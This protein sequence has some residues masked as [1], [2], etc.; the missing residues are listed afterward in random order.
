M[1]DLPSFADTAP[2]L[3]QRE[4]LRAFLDMWLVDHGFIRDIY[5]NL[6]RIS[7][8]AW[9]SAQ[10]APRHL[11]RA[12]RLGV[13]TVLNLRGRRDT[14]G[15]YILEREACQRL[16]LA[17]VDFP[18]RSRSPL[19]RDTLKAAAELFPQLEYPILMHCKSGADRAGLMATLYLHLHEGV[20]MRRAM[21][22]LSLRYG[23]IRHAKTGVSDF[24]FETYLKAS[25]ASPIAFADWVASHYDPQELARQFRQNW[26]AAVLVDRILRRE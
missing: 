6:H 26:A 2:A 7:E 18:I 15:S 13:R 21:G 14:C 10:P 3:T 25:A 5:C 8:N 4:R 22:Q 16:G 12:K 11:A 9:R 17:L 19:D 1:V 20:P 24:L 23:H